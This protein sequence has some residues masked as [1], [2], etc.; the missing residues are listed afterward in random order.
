MYQ[1]NKIAHQLFFLMVFISISFFIIISRLS[2]LQI[3]YGSFYYE[4]CQ[5]NYSKIEA[6][7]AQRG[8]ILDSKN[9]I[10]A[11]NIPLYH[12]LW[13]GTGNKTLSESQRSLLS[14]IQQLTD[15]P[16]DHG[17]AYW[18]TIEKAERYQR[19]FTLVH[20]ISFESMSKIIERFPD[21][22]NI[23]IEPSFQRYYP[24]GTIAAHIVGY[25]TNTIDQLHNGKIGIEKLCNDSLMGKNGK[26]IKIT[27]SFGQTIESKELEPPKQGS[28]IN[29]TLDLNIQKI[30][31]LTFPKNLQGTIIVMDPENGDIQALLSRPSFD[32]TI[33]LHS[34]SQ[35]QWRDLQKNQP[36]INRALSLYPPGSIFKLITISAALEN[37]YLAKDQNWQCE[38]FINFANRKYWCHRRWGHGNLST[39]QAIAQ[40]C[41]ILFFEVGKKIDID[42]ITHYAHLF[43][44]GE[45]TGFPLSDK[46]GIIPSREWKKQ[47]KG[48]PWW[49]GETLSVAIGQSYLMVTPLQI[50]RMIGSIFTGYLVKPRILTAE[51]IEKIKLNMQPSTLDFLKES[52]H[53][54]IAKGTGKRINTIKDIEIFAKTSTAQIADFKKRMLGKQFLEHAWFVAYFKYKTH[55]PLILVILVEHAGTSQIAT[56]IA[57]DFLHCYK[58]IDHF[59]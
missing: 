15:K 2:F 5:K 53:F 36:F 12:I 33:F 37:G 16:L 1:A 4:R 41:N 58:Q 38:G 50:S 31:E 11:T 43:G 39:I 35:Q 57:R 9:R 46:I 45:K 24:H 42:L 20:N 8:N 25:I 13:H 55:K 30:A 7:P 48:E 27:N 26:K 28:D 32:P 10:L 23:S 34:L 40:S 47:E 19:E 49:P 17:I 29:T 22:P 6:I 52:M 21:H 59:L 3:L 44:L 54:V 51:P 14:Y 18:K 56:S